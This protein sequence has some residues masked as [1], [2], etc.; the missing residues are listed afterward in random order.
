M[1]FSPDRV[2][3]SVLERQL[4]PIQLYLNP[5]Q[6]GNTVTIESNIF[7]EKSNSLTVIIQDISGAAAK[8]ESLSSFGNQIRINTE[9]L[10]RGSYFVAV[11]KKTK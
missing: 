2:P 9:G 8:E 7:A 3:T 1:Q 10:I 5:A 11:L 6:I 4:V